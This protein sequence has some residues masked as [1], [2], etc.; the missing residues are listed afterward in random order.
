MILRHPVRSVRA[1][2]PETRVETDASGLTA[3]VAEV[4]ESLDIETHVQD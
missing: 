1:L 2:R 3:D 4:F